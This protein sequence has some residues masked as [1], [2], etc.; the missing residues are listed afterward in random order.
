MCHDFGSGEKI[1]STAGSASPAGFA[2][3][4]AA[5]NGATRRTDATDPT[6][7]VAAGRRRRQA[8][9]VDDKKIKLSLVR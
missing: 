6:R 8:S 5:R 2:P 7:R 4:I 3:R 9:G 1:D